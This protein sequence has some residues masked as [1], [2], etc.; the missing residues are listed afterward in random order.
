MRIGR[1]QVLVA[2]VAL[3]A[4]CTW[5]FPLGGYG[6]DGGSDASRSD[7]GPPDVAADAKG[8]EDVGAREGDAGEDAAC[9]S[10]GCRCLG[11]CDMRFMKEISPYYALLWKDCAC[12]KDLCVSYCGDATAREPDVEAYCRNSFP[13]SEQAPCSN[14]LNGVA[15]DGGACNAAIF[16]DCTSRECTSYKAC[17]MSCPTGCDY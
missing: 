4:G 8:P 13:H 14:C 1:R 7:A 12:A 5:L 2:S 9:E 11:C 3:C 17:V 16:D 10:L 15:R 6:P